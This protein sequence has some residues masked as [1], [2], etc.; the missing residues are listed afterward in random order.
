MCYKDSQT[1]SPQQGLFLNR[2]TQSRLSDAFTSGFQWL[3]PFERPPVPGIFRM[4]ALVD[5]ERDL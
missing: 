3:L 5:T 4:F 1:S 2:S